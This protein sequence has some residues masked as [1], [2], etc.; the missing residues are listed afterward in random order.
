MKMIR[1]L[2]LIWLI[3]FGLGWGDALFAQVDR[4]WREHHYKLHADSSAS[5]WGNLGF[6][7]K[8]N[9]LTNELL[10]QAFFQ[11]RISREATRYLIAENN[12][13]NTYLSGGVQSSL[14]YKLPKKGGAQLM[15]GTKIY[16]FAYG[17]ITNGLSKLY[18]NGNADNAGREIPLGK[19]S[20]DY[21][22]FQ[23]I[24]TGLEW[25]NTNSRFGITLGLVKTSRYQRLRIAEGSTFYT[26]PY[27]QWLEASVNMEYQTTANKQ[28]KPG[29]WYGTGMISDIY[30]GHTFNEENSHLSIELIDLGFIH[31]GGSQQFTINKDTLFE[32]LVLN[33]LLSL[34]ELSNESS[35]GLDSIEGLIGLEEGNGS[36]I[37]IIPGR[38]Q[39]TYNHRFSPSLM[40]SVQLRQYFYA[41]PPEVRLGVNM[42][43]AEWLSVEP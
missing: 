18:F 35:P 12:E 20:L 1:N 16:D 6:E 4:A 31:F 27:G 5:L 36:N 7:L 14:W 34:D 10:N 15:F 40:G 23:S 8:S 28:E 17:R 9:L 11:G 25:E 2:S 3:L 29:A 19:S 38:F 13:Q 37:G 21:L 26:A 24:A 30:F 33:N 22:S 39:L 32:G 41:A 42:S 43:L